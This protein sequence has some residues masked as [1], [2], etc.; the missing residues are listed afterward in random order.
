MTGCV[1]TR[2][3]GS[4]ILI[5]KEC[6]SG[7]S[8]SGGFSSSFPYVRFLPFFFGGSVKRP[9]PSLSNHLWLS[10][11]SIVSPLVEVVVAGDSGATAG[12]SGPVAEMLGAS[13]SAFYASP[14][15]VIVVGV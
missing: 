6:D 9:S 7:I 1:I 5:T 13:A 4:G 12:V 15:L 2:G 14:V 8:T 3:C 11:G 10:P